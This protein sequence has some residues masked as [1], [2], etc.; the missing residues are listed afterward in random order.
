MRIKLIVPPL[1]EHPA[2]L[3]AISH[4]RRPLPPYGAGCLAASLRQRGHTVLLADLSVHTDLSAAAT[5]AMSALPMHARIGDH[6]SGRAP[7]PEVDRF[8]EILYARLTDDRPDLYGFSILSRLGLACALLLARKIKEKTGAPIVFGGALMTEYGERK[9]TLTLESFFKEHDYIDY[10]VTGEGAYPLHKL[11]ECLLGAAEL[12]SVTGLTYRRA[13]AAVRR[14]R[15][16]FDLNEMPPPDFSGLHLEAYCAGEPPG[17][18]GG[19]ATARSGLTLPYQ[20]TRGCAQ[21][22]AFCDF[23]LVSRKVEFKAAAKAVSELALMRD[24]YGTNSFFFCE[25][26]INV[27]YRHLEGFCE[28]LTARKHG[29]R[30]ETVAG[31]NNMDRA[32]LHK[33]KLAG[34]WNLTWGVES[35]SDRML[36]S[37]NKGFTSSQ[38]SDIL[39]ASHEEGIINCVNFI[40]GAPGETEADVEATLSFIRRNSGLI[41]Y[42]RVFDFALVPETPIFNDPAGYGIE[43]V[44]LDYA[45]P[46]GFGRLRYDETGGLKWEDLLKKKVAAYEKVSSEALKLL[47][48][49]P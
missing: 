20:L 23:H 1:F 48:K 10:I 9:T 3:R 15:G 43:N 32:L 31:I 13:G 18:P 28:E 21:R 33:M 4:V 46:V 17:H 7:D 24:S 5:R 29:L 44:A 14:G 12:S 38:A 37:L 41:D 39:K 8:S 49:K 36:L 6:L 19:R 2:Q 35:G 34:C 40:T 30:W 27:S 45:S 11:T 26:R 25:S 47:K 16:T 42:P 22:C